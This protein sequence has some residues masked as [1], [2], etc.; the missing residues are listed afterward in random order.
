MQS[1]AEA[2]RHA[3][4]TLIAPDF[5]L[6]ELDHIA[7]AAAPLLPPPSAPWCEVSARV[8][9]LRGTTPAALDATLAPRTDDEV[10]QLLAHALTERHASTADNTSH[11]AV[12]HEAAAE[13]LLGELARR[14]VL[15]PEQRT[16]EQQQRQASR[17]AADRSVREPGSALPARAAAARSRST[18]VTRT[19]TGKPS[20]SGPAA[21]PRPSDGFGQRRGR[22]R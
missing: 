12:R 2:A 8:A 7:R 11:T 20:T 17:T 1:P 19:P 16:Q 22:S 13:R 10:V 9:Q 15:S 6:P 4:A 18:T 3:A 5:A 14:A 21:S